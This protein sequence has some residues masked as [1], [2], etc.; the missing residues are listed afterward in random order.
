MAWEK[1]FGVDIPINFNEPYKAVN[2]A[3]FWKRWHITMTGFFTKYL[4]IP[5]GGNR[6]GRY[7]TYLNVMI[8]FTLSGLWH[9]AAWAFVLWGM[10]HGLA[11]V[12]HRIFKS[13]IE[14]LPHILTGFFTFVFVN[15]AWVL[16]RTESI[17]R[18][19]QV[20]TRLFTGGFS[21]D[22][23]DLFL[24]FLG[25]NP[26]ILL[27]NISYD[28]TGLSVFAA[29]FTVVCLLA[30]LL[31]VFLAPS[32]HRIAGRRMAFA[33]EGVVFALMAVLSVMTFTN[34]S[35]FLYFNF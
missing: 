21:G 31:V 15:L 23:T 33:G 2:I 28:Q 6:K 16:F 11:L 1:L 5:L 10:L 9:G 3:E 30:A 7:R 19:K 25:D 34:V 29:V 8:V 24:A 12:F 18:A 26:E 17:G 32:S 13:Y 4:Y 27:Q 14:K 22:N 35:T 20:L